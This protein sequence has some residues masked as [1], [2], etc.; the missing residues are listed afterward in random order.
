MVMK[1]K[2]LLLKTSRLLYGPVLCLA[3]VLLAT[4]A[5][6][7]ADYSS[8][9]IFA[10]LAGKTLPNNAS[11]KAVEKT[12]WTFHPKGVAVDTEG[13]T[14]FSDTRHQII[15]KIAPSGTVTVIAGSTSRIGS[16]DGPN[17][18]ARF[19]NP[20]G[21]AVDAGGNIYVADS[22]NNTIRKVTPAGV[23]TTLAG[24]PGTVGSDDGKGG[25]ARFNYP[26]SVAVDNSGNVYVADLYNNAIRKITPNGRVT[27]LAGMAGE[28]GR[29]NGTGTNAHF[30]APVSV[31]VDSSGNVFVA[32]MFN[33][34]IRK[35][36]PDGTVSTFAGG[37][38]YAAGNADGAGSAAQFCHPR[39]L[40]V[41]GSDNLYVADADNNTIRRISP[42][43]NVVTLA[44]LPGQSGCADGTG[45]ATRFWHPVS[46][47]LDHGGEVYVTDLDNAAIRKGS[48]ASTA[49]A[50]FSF[51][52][53]KHFASIP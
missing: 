25:A 22:G 47:A 45:K 31:A 9:Y 44:G 14:Y 18:A 19:H 38:S 29:V 15:C 30:N 34:A 12:G 33:N 5:S 23:V 41:D 21:I 39:G 10:T 37:M 53:N 40:A 3:L 8:P 35:I 26:N 32:D 36:T 4:S 50:T 16:A 51:R 46:I 1:T 2:N 17:S 42:A 20:Q 13:N 27:T 7:Q 11:N 24:Q 6:C 43:G 49:D 48:P 28:F 52:M